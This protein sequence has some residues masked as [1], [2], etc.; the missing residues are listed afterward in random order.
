[1][2]DIEFNDSLSTA[3]TDKNSFLYSRIQKSGE[4]PTLVNFLIKKGIVG[5]EK[6][7]NMTLLATTVVFFLAAIS[8]I[9][10]SFYYTPTPNKANLPPQIQIIQKTQ[11]YIRQGMTPQD[12]R[13]R[14]VDEV[15][16]TNSAPAQ[17]TGSNSTA[18]SAK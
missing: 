15:T 4:R 7:A 14:A 16:P 13:Q 1:M 6:S 9:Y 3:S 11:D 10:Y 5:S 12:A 2:S 8:V 17:D 18:P